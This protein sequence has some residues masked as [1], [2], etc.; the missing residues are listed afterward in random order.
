MRRLFILSALF[1]VL[2][3]MSQPLMACAADSAAGDCCPAGTHEPQDAFTDGL[4]GHDCPDMLL[5]ATPPQDPAA[6]STQARKNL[7]MLAASVPAGA[8]ST[9]LP[10]LGP[11]APPRA[12]IGR[13]PD[14]SAAF[15]AATASLTYL[16]TA[17][18]RL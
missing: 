4:A 12:A 3:A 7:P 18:L 6:V 8:D 14:R 1:S 10:A 15:A 17:R 13:A 2:L 16:H 9:P 5:C 11:R